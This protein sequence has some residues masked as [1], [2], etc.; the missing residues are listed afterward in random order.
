M[1]AVDRL[2]IMLCP[3]SRKGGACRKSGYLHNVHQGYAMSRVCVRRSSSSFTDRAEISLIMFW[4]RPQTRTASTR[5]EYIDQLFD[6]AAT[7]PPRSTLCCRLRDYINIIII[8]AAV[9]SARGRPAAADKKYKPSTPAVSNL[10]IFNDLFPPLTRLDEIVKRRIFHW[11]RRFL[12]GPL[13]IN[14]TTYWYEPRRVTDSLIFWAT[15]RCLTS[16]NFV[17]ELKPFNL[18]PLDELPNMWRFL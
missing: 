13:G 9:F 14:K 5:R 8:P 6:R 1:P 4:S 3:S 11:F 16:L 15:P 10:V 17:L 18:K 2:N 12:R 7:A